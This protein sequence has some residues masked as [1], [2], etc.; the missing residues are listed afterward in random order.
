[1]TLY[2]PFSKLSKAKHLLK[3]HRTLYDQLISQLSP[4]TD[5]V[6]V[7]RNESIHL[8]L[9]ELRLANHHLRLAY[10]DSD[11]QWCIDSKLPLAPGVAVHCTSIYPHYQHSFRYTYPTLSPNL[12]PFLR[13]AFTTYN[14]S[15]VT[16][17][18]ASLSTL[19]DVPIFTPN[20]LAL[21]DY[22][23]ANPCN[24]HYIDQSDIPPLVLL[25][26]AKHH[27]TDLFYY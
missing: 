12:S 20:A 19:L 22:L 15:V 6:S 18:L 3:T 11:D 8:K 17:K 24:C 21:H 26:L 5:P 14:R 23:S 27:R 2:N 25:A 10:I 16:S 7:L 9:S 4:N 13:A 1:M